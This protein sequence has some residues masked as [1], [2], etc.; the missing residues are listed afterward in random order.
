[1][2]RLNFGAFVALAGL[3]V[4]AMLFFAAMVAPRLAVL[5]K[6][7]MGSITQVLPEVDDQVLTE[8]GFFLDA[9]AD[10]LAALGEAEYGFYW[11]AGVDPEALELPPPTIEELQFQIEELRAR[12]DL[13]EVN[14][15]ACEPVERL[16]V[17]Y[18]AFKKM[19]PSLPRREPA[20]LFV[21]VGWGEEPEPNPFDPM[22]LAWCEVMTASGNLLCDFPPAEMAQDIEGQPTF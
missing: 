10:V 3:S 11:E 17:D 4:L 7:A 2:K 1:M 22:N 19:G 6:A 13:H 18:A 20:D 16:P 15:V 8:E 9:D 12:L 21:N 5:Q 14:S